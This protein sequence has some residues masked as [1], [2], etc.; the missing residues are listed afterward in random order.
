MSFQEQ[1]GREEVAQSCTLLYRRVALGWASETQRNLTIRQPCRLQI[2]DTAECN[3]ALRGWRI[4]LILLL[5]FALAA[6]NAPAQQQT[7]SPPTRDEVLRGAL[8]PMRTCYDVTSYE[9]D[10]RIDPAAETLSGSNKIRFRTM[11]DF[12]KLQ[13]DLFTNLAIEKI[14]FDDT[15]S[16]TFTR[17]LGAVFVQ[18]PEKI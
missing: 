13:I 7:N 6:L 12:D 14:V 18:L 8:G 5:L 17:E 4:A 11:E 9:L 2:C 3:S 10:V 15:R 16:A 1:S